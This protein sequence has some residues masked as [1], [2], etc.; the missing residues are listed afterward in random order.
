MDIGFW[1]PSL[2]VN[3]AVFW[4]QF[5]AT[6]FLS[7]VQALFSWKRPW[8]TEPL[9]FVFIC[10]QTKAG[11]SLT[12]SQQSQYTRS[13]IQWILNGMSICPRLLVCPRKASRW[14]FSRASHRC[15]SVNSTSS[16]VSIH[17]P[18]CLFHSCKFFISFCLLLLRI[19]VT[20]FSLFC[21]QEMKLI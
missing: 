11:L 13:W 15:D 12:S 16:H 1:L 18:L 5:L 3:L 7:V 19:I 20:P 21:S 14:L 17:Q 4:W 6:I 10:I 9:R 8:E 2:F